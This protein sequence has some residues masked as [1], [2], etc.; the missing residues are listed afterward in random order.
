MVLSTLLFKRPAFQNLVCNGLVLAADGKK[1]S[2][3]L[4]NYP[5]RPSSAPCPTWLTGKLVAASRLHCL[6]SDMSHVGH[7]WS[8]ACHRL[9]LAAYSRKDEQAPQGHADA[10]VSCQGR[11]PGLPCPKRRPLM[12]SSVGPPIS[13]C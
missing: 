13:S 2:K 12:P 6:A 4:K 3:R 10:P 7:L 11:I 9:V 1:M 5:V 8:L